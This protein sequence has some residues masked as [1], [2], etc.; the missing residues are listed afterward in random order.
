VSWLPRSLVGRITLLAAAGSVL[1]LVL[2]GALV[3]AW[4]DDTGQQ[5]SEALAGR[6]RAVHLQLRDAPA[7]ARPVLAQRLSDARFSVMRAE[8]L[9]PDRP[10]RPEPPPFAGA[11]PPPRPPG[12]PDPRLE[13]LRRSLPAGLHLAPP[14][15]EGLTGAWRLRVEMP[16]DDE[17][18]QIEVQLPPSGPALLGA[19]LGWLVLVALVV[20]ASLAL[21][22]RWVARPLAELARRLA[23]QGHQ[24]QPLASEGQA[25]EVQQL[26]AA[27]NQLAEA[28]Q[29]AEGD[30][31]HLLAGV[32]HDLRTP[33]ARL[34]LRIET[35]VDA[36]VAEALLKDVDAIKRIVAQFLAYVQGEIES[37][38]GRPDDAAALLARLVAAYAAEGHDVRFRS[39]GCAAELPDLAL[40]R[41]ATNLIDNALAHGLPP[42]QV[43]LLQQGT[44]ARLRVA[45]AGSG[46]DGLEFAEAQR[47][48]VRGASRDA[49]L[50]HSGLGL[51]I[52]AQLSR[53]LGARLEAGVDAEGRF[54]VALY[55]VARRQPGTGA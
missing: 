22:A 1:S 30:R 53:Q 18:W 24:I 54:G 48:F 17:D 2:H 42:V 41:I 6:V 38:L 25:L 52:V 55:W 37:R 36:P 21:G 5:L 31:R 51:A 26:T 11:E 14:L 40:Q 8:G 33:L 16:L 4:A 15:R 44:E 43:S 7:A 35:Q 46:M 20:F 10:P 19:T 50:G 9:W 27:F 3:S 23:A 47:P 12:G 29:R 32:S 13:A 34:R 28:V 39:D 49:S 45:D